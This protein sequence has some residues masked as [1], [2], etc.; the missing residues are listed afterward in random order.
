[1]RWN[2]GVPLLWR[3]SMG[4]GAVFAL[5]LPL[6]TEESDFVLRP[7]FLALLERFVGTARSRGGTRLVD[8]GDSFTFDGYKDVSVQFVPVRAGESPLKMELAEQAGRRLLVTALAG[9]YVAQTDGE[10]S[11]RIATIPEREIDLRPRRIAD[12]AR[13]ETQGGVQPALDISPY[14]A[15]ALIGLFALE[16]MLRTWGQRKEAA[17]AA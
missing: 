8:V 17:E 10:Q 4:R 11:L 2:D 7:A 12:T 15:L 16:L 1:V 5:S 13:A 9:R 3:K 6:S 14:V